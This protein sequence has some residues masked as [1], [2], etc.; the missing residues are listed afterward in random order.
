M[1][2]GMMTLWNAANGPSIH[3]ELIGR[4]W[5]KMGHELKVFSSIKHP[6][7]RPTGQED[8]DFVIRHFIVDNVVP[9]TRAS[10]FDPSPLLDED[11]EIFVAQNVERLPVERLLELFPK[12]KEKAVTVQIVHEGKPSEDPLYY[13]FNWDAIVCFDERYREYLL[14]FFPLNKIK[15]IPYPYH[16]FKLG[17]KKK[18]REKLNL[19]LDKKI[20]FSFGFRTENVLDVL[21]TLSS[22]EKDYPLKYLVVANSESETRLLYEVK[23]KYDF[24]DIRVR[25]I[26]LDELYTYLH[27]SDVLLVHR[28]SSK[29]KAVVSSTICQV[30]GSG[31]PVLFHESNYVEKHGDEIIKYTDFEDMKNK[32]IQIF[33][34]EF[35]LNE[36]IEEFLKEHNAE[37][38][39][40]R[41]I[42]LFKEL[43]SVRKRGI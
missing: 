23:E 31:C 28:E 43:L 12:I 27:A 5:V 10:W 11:Y 32:M 30:L 1:K 9:V 35:D 38:I 16:P 2:I 34:G 7:A 42:N 3:A 18:A 15:M 8:E 24:L 41:Y 26:P 40:E 33:N 39:A 22:I 21:P 19:P 37:K 36:K 14:E 25:A 20:V 17:D 6:D 13:K 4:A 29:Y